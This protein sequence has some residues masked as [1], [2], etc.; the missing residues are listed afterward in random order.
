MES[1][2]LIRRT[3][4]TQIPRVHRFMY[5]SLPRRR[6]AVRLTHPGPFQKFQKENPQLV[7]IDFK[8]QSREGPLDFCTYPEVRRMLTLT[9]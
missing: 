7:A 1:Q 3:G 6:R 2:E 9:I 5:Y 8:G 4:T